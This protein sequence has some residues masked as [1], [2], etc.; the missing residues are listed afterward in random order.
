MR[1][2]FCHFIPFD[3]NVCS[4]IC[5][6]FLVSSLTCNLNFQ[7]L[8]KLPSTSLVHALYMFRPLVIFR[9]LLFSH[10]QFSGCV[11]VYAS[12]CPEL[13]RAEQSS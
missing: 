7:N 8:Y 4:A 10:V 12:M 6:L 5:C 9:C 3:L 13:S 1:R 2:F 11:P